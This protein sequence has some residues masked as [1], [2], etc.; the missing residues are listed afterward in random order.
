MVIPRGNDCKF[1]DDYAGAGAVGGDVDVVDE[2]QD[3]FAGV[4]LADA[5]VVELS[6]MV[7]VSCRWPV[8]V[9]LYL[10]V[11]QGVMTWLAFS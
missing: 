10:E 4:V 7:E 6:G 1:V 11:C 9:Q 2:H 5:N 3:F 8:L